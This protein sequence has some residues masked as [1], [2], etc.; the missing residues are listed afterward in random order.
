M[1]RLLIA[2]LLLTLV[3]QD[4]PTRPAPDFPNVRYGDHVRNVLYC[5]MCSSF[6]QL[7]PSFEPCD[8][9][10]FTRHG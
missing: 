4:K 9:L 2:V 7:V 3:P 8:G 1:S 10:R 5:D 6:L